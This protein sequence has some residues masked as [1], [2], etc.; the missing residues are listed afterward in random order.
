M[1]SKKSFDEY[2]DI[3]IPHAYDLVTSASIYDA[4][5]SG[6]NTIVLGTFG[7]VILFICATLNN[8]SKIKYEIKREITFKH[9]VMGLSPTHLSSNAAYDLVV[10]TLNGISIWQYEPDRLI[11]F[12]NQKFELN[13]HK[14]LELINSKINKID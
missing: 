10:M 4:T 11:E 13:E 14:Y 8:E 9:S 2:Q 7:K 6:Y 3:E 5:F 1:K 12:I